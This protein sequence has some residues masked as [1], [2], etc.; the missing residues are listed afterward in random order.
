MSSFLSPSSP[1]SQIILICDWNP[2]GVYNS[3]T[4]TYVQHG[5]NCTTLFVCYD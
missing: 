4:C 5:W 2:Y 1:V 3:H